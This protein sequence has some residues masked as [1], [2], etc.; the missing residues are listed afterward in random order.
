LCSYADS[1]AKTK[2]YGGSPHVI[3]GRIEAEHY[4]DGKPL[5]AYRDT[6][7]IN[8]GVDYRGTTHVDIEKRADASNGHG[9][10]WTRK[11]EWVVYTVSVKESGIYDLAIP[12]AS[13]KKG[14]TFHL[15]FDG[16]DVTGPIEVPDTGGW[17]K[18]QLITKKGLRLQDG[19]HVMTLAMDSEGPSGSI[20]DIDY[21][22][23]QGGPAGR[24]ASP[25]TPHD[26]VIRL[27]NGKNFDGLYT[28]LR[29]NKFDDPL[30]VFRISDG[31]LQITGEQLGA[32]I[33]KDEYR[34]YHL[35]VEF[36]WGERTWGER[37]AR[38]RDSGVLIHS[39]GA[40]GGYNGV[41]MPSIEA[42][43]I[44]G[45]TGDFILVLGNEEDGRPVPISLTSEMG[46]DR[47]GNPIWMKGEKREVVDRNNRK[48][49]NWYGRDPDWTDT[50]GF[51][52]A[53]DVE[54]PFGQW[55]RM[56]VICDGGH[57][58]ILVNGTM[59]NEAF[60]AYPDYGKIQLQSE[61]AEV[62]FRR[63]EL[64]PLGKAPP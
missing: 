18:L 26:G 23:F 46:R 32:V 58:Q 29:D 7:E 15:E 53:S 51:R 3:P 57:I 61:L 30:N 52:G 17:Q 39:V 59:V 48:R 55:T 28:W 38:T 45:G 62:F 13:D 54:S 2:P 43:I 22:D 36:K 42:Q 10:G 21:L 63:F 8:E 37:K 50:I 12:V 34:D 1:N 27:F 19:I 64:W 4:D 49:I 14:G 6:D 60:D 25:I 24:G 41:W 40:N 47:K 11:G 35:I 16:K 20:G 5:E 9:I 56:D 31:M 33:T 44:E